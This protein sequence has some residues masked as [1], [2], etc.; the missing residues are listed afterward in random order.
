MAKSFLME[1]GEVGNL[2]LKQLTETRQ[3]VTNKWEKLGLLE[4][5]SGVQKEN[6]AQLYENQLSQ[7]MNESTDSNASGQFETVAFPVIR[8]VFSKLLAN[9]IVSVQALNLPIGKLFYINPKIS[10]RDNGAHKS[11]DG[12]YSNAAA[13]A[14]SA[15]TQFESISL[16]DSYYATAAND[17]GTSLFDRSKGAIT[18]TTGNV[19]IVTGATISAT[20]SSINTISSA[21]I[22]AVIPGFRALAGTPG[23]L[24]GP[25]GHPMDT[26]EFLSSLTIAPSVAL[27]ANDVTD[28]SYDVAA[29]ASLPFNVKVQQYG[30]PMVDDN[31]NLVILIDCSYGGNDG[32]KSLSASTTGLTFSYTFKTYSDLEEDS[33]M[34]E[35]T[36]TLDEVTVDVSTRKMRALWT[37]ELAMD[38]S[39]FHNIDAE[40][41][42]TALL[43]EQMAAEI[44]RE[45]LR[46]LRRGAAWATRWDN[47]GFLKR[48]NGFYGT[49]KDYNQ[50][51]ITKINQISAQ[52]HKATL[53]GGASWIVVSPEVSAIFDDLEYFHVSNANPEQD[54]YNMGI[55]KV[56]TLQG[57][58]IVY[59]DPYAPASSILIGHKGT[60]ILE[61]GYIYAPYVPM[62]LT[63]AMQDPRDFKNVRGILTRYAKKMILNRY[64]GKITVDGVTTFGIGDL[65]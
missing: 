54:K 48:S 23:K 17:E 64:Y 5:L 24:T 36:F 6:I 3:I 20:A 45:I 60:S 34:A 29:A 22:T 43:S 58:Y 44:D 8:R 18:T 56:G 50:E 11:Y 42:L 33:E 15:K 63:A 19:L 35:V 52:I 27:V 49:K 1:C 31:G 30:K 37:P 14:S 32:Y 46:D 55:E 51:L 2:G 7:M 59:R 26:E 39:A 16:Y 40:A 41:E 10:S 21:Y 28:G 13:L 65:K 12:A 4:G 9:D 61:A 57:R 47:N 53:R 25:S 38:V 62:Q